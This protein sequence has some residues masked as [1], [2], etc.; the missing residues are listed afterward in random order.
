MTTVNMEGYPG[1]GYQVT[2]DAL[3]PLAGNR[4]Y[5]GSRVRPIPYDTGLPEHLVTAE[6]YARA[7]KFEDGESSNSSLVTLRSG[8]GTGLRRTITSVTSV[9]DFQEGN[10]MHDGIDMF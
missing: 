8:F 6:E 4:Q 9:D 10:E 2:S 3:P 5:H 1:E 7:R